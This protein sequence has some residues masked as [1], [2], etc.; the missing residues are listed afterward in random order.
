MLVTDVP[1]ERLVPYAR[2]PRN[3][4]KAIDAVKASIA[5]FGFRQPIVVDE[6]MVVIVGHTR[7]EAAKALGLNL[8]S[9][10]PEP[11]K[12]LAT[13][14]ESAR[15]FTTRA[16]AVRKETRAQTAELTECTPGHFVRAA[17]ISVSPPG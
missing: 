12:R 3:N 10:L 14:G 13:A 16:E 7:L 1:V 15:D 17:A 2:N 6:K 5:E 11:G 4:A 9:A 8:L